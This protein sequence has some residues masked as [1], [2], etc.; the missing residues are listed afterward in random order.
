MQGADGDE[1]QGGVA[2]PVVPPMVA[3]E[4]I[5]SDSEMA[6]RLA[7]EE[8]S[9]EDQENAWAALPFGVSGMS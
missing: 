9:L 6:R 2:V 7:L 3:D 8:G 1:D 5:E 4:E